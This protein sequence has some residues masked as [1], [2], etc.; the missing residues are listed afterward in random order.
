MPGEELLDIGL[1]GLDKFVNSKYYDRAYDSFPA[2]K[3]R[4]S[5]LRHRRRSRGQAD[6]QEVVVDTDGPAPRDAEYD[7]HA[8]NSQ[9][10]QDRGESMELVRYEGREDD[11]E[12]APPPPPPPRSQ[13]ARSTVYEQERCRDHSPRSMRDYRRDYD[14]ASLRG[15]REPSTVYHEERPREQP[16]YRVEAERYD[17]EFSR[18]RRLRRP[19]PRDHDFDYRGRPRDRRDVP[20]SYDLD[21]SDRRLLSREIITEEY[22][23][24]DQ[25]QQ[26]QRARSEYTRTEAPDRT[27][28][29]SVSGL[30]QNRE[31]FSNR[32]YQDDTDSEDETARNRKDFTRAYVETS[33]FNNVEAA[34]ARAAGNGRISPAT[35][36]DA[37][38]AR[39]SF[40]RARSRSTRRPTFV[41]PLPS[42]PRSPIPGARP[43]GDYM[44]APHPRAAAAAAAMS[45]SRALILRGEGEGELDGESSTVA[46]S[47]AGGGGAA[48]DEVRY[49]SGPRSFS[50]SH[51][52]IDRAEWDRDRERGT[53]IDRV[54]RGSV[55]SVQSSTYP[56]SRRRPAERERERDRDLLRPPPRST[57]PPLPRAGGRGRSS[58]RP[59]GGGIA[60]TALGA[61]AGGFVGTELSKG[62]TLATVAAAVVGAMGAH[63]AERKYEKRKESKGRRED[64]GAYAALGSERERDEWDWQRRTR[65][66]SR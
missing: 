52:S 49:R 20:R 19:P 1:D 26:Q 33:A 36:S 32:Y 24:P 31:P 29:L 47:R 35:T 51:H 40:R 56:A 21:L 2:A 61:L 11:R 9:W 15:P 60:S 5:R 34:A 23:P 17:D 27:R 44:P 38:P 50:H 39:S 45:Q 55:R 59:P 65:R 53:G 3:R 16:N 25:Q 7:G 30:E 8:R 54:R 62:N 6:Q 58:S 43:V 28:A 12:A 4:L 57:T 46:V 64:A 18:P 13:R 63:E 14:E 10:D 41:E 66:S 37:A 22:W 48:A 42:P